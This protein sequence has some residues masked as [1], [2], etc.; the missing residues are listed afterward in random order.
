MGHPSTLIVHHNAVLQDVLFEFPHIN[1]QHIPPHVLQDALSKF[2][3]ISFPHRKY[4]LRI[5]R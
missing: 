3:S 5:A 2:T 4:T 1:L